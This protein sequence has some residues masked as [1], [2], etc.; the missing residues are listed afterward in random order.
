VYVQFKDAAGNESASYSDTIKVDTTRPTGTLSINGGASETGQTLVTLTIADEDNGGSGVTKMRFSNDGTTWNDWTTHAQT[1]PWTLTGGHGD[2]T[3]YMQLKDGAGNESFS[4]PAYIKLDITKPGVLLT[5]SAGDATKNAPISVTATFTESVKGF[6]TGGVTVDNGTVT[7]F[8][9]TDPGTAYALTVTPAHEGAVVVHVDAGVAEEADGDRNFNVASN[10]LTVLYDNTAPSGTILINGGSAYTTTKGVSL[11]MDIADAGGSGVLE[12]RMCFSNEETPGTFSDWQPYTSSAVWDLSA[13][14]GF[15]T[16]HAQVRDMAGNVGE[17]NDSITLDTA[18]PTGTVS[19]NGDAAFVDTDEVTLTLSASDAVPGSGLSKMR[20]SN[21]NSTWSAWQTNA[22]SHAW[23]L[24]DVDG[25]TTVYAQFQDAAGNVSNSYSDTIFLDTEL[26][27]VILASLAPDT[28]AGSFSVSA[29]FIEPVTGFDVSG[30]TVTNGVVLAGSFEGSGAHYGWV[31]TPSS[32]GSVT[33]SVAAGACS[34]ADVSKKPNQASNVLARTYRNGVAPYVLLS[35]TAPNPVSGAFTAT[36]AFSEAVTGFDASDV[37]AD[38]GTVSLFEGSGTS[39][40]WTVTPATPGAVNIFVAA[41]AC[42]GAFGAGNT[43]SNTLTTTYSPAAVTIT[44]AVAINGGA[45]YTN[46]RNVA[47][48]LTATTGVTQM[49][50]SNDNSTWSDGDWVAFAATYPWELT[51]GDGDKTVYAQFRDGAGHVS[52]GE[53]SA[54]I[55]LNTVTPTLTLSTVSPGTVTTPFTVTADFSETVTGFDL[56]D[57]VVDNGTV[58]ALAGGDDS[59]SWTVTPLYAGRVT[60]SVAAGV[61]TDLATNPNVKADDLLVNY[62]APTPED[63]D[64]DGVHDNLDDFPQDDTRAFI[65]VYPSRTTWATLAF[66]DL[67]P[68]RGDYDLNDLVLRYQVATVANKDGLVKDINVTVKI[69]ARGAAN[70]SGFGIELPGVAPNSVVTEYDVANPN[71]QPASLATTDVKHYVFPRTTTAPIAPETGQTGL[72]WIFFDDGSLYDPQHDNGVYFNT[73][74]KSPKKSGATFA[75]KMTFKTAQPVLTVGLPPYNAFIFRTENR[76][77]E[78]HLANY[79]P[80]SKVAL[81][82]G[83]IFGTGDDNSSVADG[84]YYVTSDKTGA[85]GLPWALN[86]ADPWN[87]PQEVKDLAAVYPVFVPWA[88]AGGHEDGDWYQR[89]MTIQ[90]L[91]YNY[92]TITYRAK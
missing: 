11:T 45:Q 89:P 71:D 54:Y 76:V 48:T 47:L 75:L 77:Q 91:Y 39:Y 60:V 27:S 84:R 9:G 12:M 49:R 6:T 90:R 92:Q 81:G 41:G 52:S 68:A 30:V 8:S 83:S 37:V 55:A 56:N 2:K 17:F 7:G 28:V 21:D 10:V 82:I 66:E 25:I 79:P 16:V 38:N 80:T 22:A 44:G 73:D 85:A 3:V 43:Q 13:D 32:N 72:T 20:F 63:I 88:N 65:N 58:S 67:W 34:D 29:D 53:I 36:A 35:T 46:S 70:K 14:D 15:K 86:F 33:V 1:A 4:I 24:A 18:A 19:I 42:Q 5:T 26:L 69:Q 23:T 62:I 50:F 51:V 61:C 78:V 31:V 87:H 64:G 59:Y 57:V 74:P 40:S